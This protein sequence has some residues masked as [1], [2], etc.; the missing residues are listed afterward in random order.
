MKGDKNGVTRNENER[1]WIERFWHFESVDDKTCDVY[2]TQ[3]LLLN[4]VKWLKWKKN[5]G[6]IDVFLCELGDQYVLLLD[7]VGCYCC[8]CCYFEVWNGSAKEGVFRC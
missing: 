7:D 1:D 2:E 6:Q 5:L 3:A 4:G 8:Y